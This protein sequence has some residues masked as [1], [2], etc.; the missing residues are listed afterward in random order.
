M[1]KV[2]DTVRERRVFTKE[3]K[4]RAVEPAR[5]TN[6]KRPETV[7]DLGILTGICRHDGSGR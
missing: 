1:I 6:R 2:E 7:Q 4:K 3:F 5:N